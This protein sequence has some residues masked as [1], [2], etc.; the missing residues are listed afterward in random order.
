MAVSDA[1]VRHVAGL[2]RLGLTDA[3][4]HALAGELNQI[5]EHMD[6]LSKVTTDAV[7]VDGV[8]AG[9]MP[10]RADAGPPYP[11]AHGFETIAPLIRDAFILVPRLATHGT[12]VE[13]GA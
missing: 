11:L 1:D 4:V 12:P 6:V 13:E 5:L 8:A 3:R 10:L 7:P 9:G 2:A